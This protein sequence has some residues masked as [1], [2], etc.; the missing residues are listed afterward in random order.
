MVPPFVFN[1][2]GE[3]GQRAHYVVSEPKADARFLRHGHAGISLYL[4]RIR[5]S[6][7]RASYYLA[8][9]IVLISWRWALI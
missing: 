8:T 9:T 1:G 5:K 7:K 2:H 6:C 3:I 4:W